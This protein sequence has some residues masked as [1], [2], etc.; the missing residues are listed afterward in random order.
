MRIIKFNMLPLS[1]S[2]PGD[3]V[4]LLLLLSFMMMMMMMTSFS[5]AR[6]PSFKVMFHAYE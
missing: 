2:S 3:D 6:E 4:L 1:F 5:L